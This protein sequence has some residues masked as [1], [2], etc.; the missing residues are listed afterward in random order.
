MDL[1]PSS[2]QLMLTGSGP[3]VNRRVLGSPVSPPLNQLAPGLFNHSP[4][5]QPEI[6]IGL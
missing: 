4:S 1:R 3:G 6:G 2:G 5:C